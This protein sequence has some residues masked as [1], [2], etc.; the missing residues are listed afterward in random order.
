[1]QET[2]KIKE[3]GLDAEKEHEVLQMLLHKETKLLQTIDRLKI[4]ANHE[5]KDLR[6]QVRFLPWTN[7][8]SATTCQRSRSALVEKTAEQML[9][10]TFELQATVLPVRRVHVRILVFSFAFAAYTERHVPA[11]AV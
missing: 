10:E 6:I 1:M 7:K 4:N 3:A 2:R 11:Q 9:K 8:A 5:N